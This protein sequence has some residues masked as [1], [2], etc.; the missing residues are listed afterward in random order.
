M[1]QQLTTTIAKHSEQ[2][3]ATLLQGVHD[4]IV[5][6]FTRLLATVPDIG[7]IAESLPA[8]A[9]QWWKGG[10]SARSC[11]TSAAVGSLA[12]SDQLATLPPIVPVMS[13][14]RS[15]RGTSSISKLI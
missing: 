4:S 14:M 11:G 5:D 2:S 12:P 15:N 6:F 1:Q 13:I 7:Y 3:D 9:S 10:S 8:T